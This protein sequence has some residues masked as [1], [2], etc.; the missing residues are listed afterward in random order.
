MEHNLYDITVTNKSCI[1]FIIRKMISSLQIFHI[2]KTLENNTFNLRH[3]DS[4]W[5]TCL[6]SVI[7]TQSHGTSGDYPGDY[8]QGIDAYCFLLELICGLH[9]S[10]IGET[11]IVAQF[12]Q[13]IQKHPFALDH[14]VAHELLKESKS[15]RSHYLKGI[16]GQSYGSYTLNQ[17]KH[18]DSIVFIGNGTLTTEI[19]PIVKKF[20]GDLVIQART[21]QKTSLLKGQFPTLKSEQLGHNCQLRDNSLVVVAAPMPNDSLNTHLSH[22]FVNT[23]VLDMRALGHHPPLQLPSHFVVQTLNEIFA[24]IQ[25]TQHKMASMAQRVREDIAMRGRKWHEQTLYRPFGWE[26]LC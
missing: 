25:S 5:G 7:F 26:D 13:F 8:Y 20:K 6:R 1:L 2:P 21:P 11:E 14:K 17:S 18:K 15:I 23:T 9:S 19:L 3:G 16:G 24:N 22:C 10:L 12:K 4:C